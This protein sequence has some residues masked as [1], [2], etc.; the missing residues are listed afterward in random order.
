MTVRRRNDGLLAGLERRAVSYALPKIPASMNSDHLTGVAFLGA[1]LA[2]A[3]LLAIKASS[4]FFIVF[5]FGIVLNWFGDSLDGALARYRR[6]ERQKIGFLLDKTCD[7][8]S[9]GTL[10]VAMGQTGFLS[11]FA[12]LMIVIAYLVHTI[13]GLMRVV[14][15]GVQIIGLDGFG[16]TEGR[17]SAIIWVGANLAFGFMP[18]NLQFGGRSL[19]D[20]FCVCTA[21]FILIRFLRGVS[22]DVERLQA[23]EGSASPAAGARADAPIPAVANAWAPRQSAEAKRIPARLP[24]R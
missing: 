4:A 11:P 13:Y 19:V 21:C 8:L 12:S 22:G 7:L 9:L 3:S 2:A 23:V 15:D 24:E 14:V 16:A 17:I 5:A 18:A 1:A 10:V 20:G 6:R